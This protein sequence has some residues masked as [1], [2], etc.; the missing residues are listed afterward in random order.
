MDNLEL[1]KLSNN[2]RFNLLDLTITPPQ[3]KTQL[4]NDIKKQMQD[5]T[6][7]IDKEQIREEVKN[8]K[9]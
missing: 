6:K 8:G 2:L 1:L 7:I 3:D 5:I 9:R 4:I